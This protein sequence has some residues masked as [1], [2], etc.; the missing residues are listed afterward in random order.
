MKPTNLRVRGK[1]VVLVPISELS[2][3]EEVNPARV[4]RMARV[5]LSSRVVEKPILVD[6][7]T[8]VI[9]DGHHRYNALR[10]IGTRYAP[11]ILLDYSRDVE[12][13]GAGSWSLRA[14]NPE[15]LM[16]LLEAVLVA[17]ASRGPHPVVIESPGVGR[18][19][20]YR[21]ALSAYLALRYSGLLGI[22]HGN[23]VHAARGVHSPRLRG[24]GMVIVRPPPLSKEHVRLVGLRGETLPPK[25]TLHVTPYKGVRAPVRL[26]RLF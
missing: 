21:D 16:D 18:R 9:I 22:D 1:D 12:G 7:K 11:A 23:S 24:G 19:V 26:D 17:H 6:E 13:I 3:H 5:I 20:V 2:V 4:T 25:S 10:A 8:L 15:R 14:E